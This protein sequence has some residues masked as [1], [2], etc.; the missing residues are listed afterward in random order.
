MSNCSPR[1]E[2]H[3]SELQSHSDLVC[4]LLLEKKNRQH[5][6]Q[7]Q[8]RR[9]HKELQLIKIS[10]P[11]L[12]FD[13]KKRLGAGRVHNKHVDVAEY[14]THFIDQAD[15]FGL[16]SHIRFERMRMTTRLPNALAELF[17]RVA[18]VEVVDGRVRAHGSHFKS[19]GSS[20]TTGCACNENGTTGVWSVHVFTLRF[21]GARAEVSWSRRTRPRRASVVMF[22]TVCL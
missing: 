21:N 22:E 2:E 15:D 13:G 10:A 19:D 7:Q 9:L 17:R 3:T 1:S 11:C 12:L 8:Q 18:A 4:R 16:T 5:L 20:K 6:L 14:V